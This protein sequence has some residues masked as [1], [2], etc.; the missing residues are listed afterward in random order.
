MVNIMKWPCITFIELI[1]SR[2]KCTP[3]PT[4]LDFSTADGN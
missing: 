4:A 1:N 3:T 2:I